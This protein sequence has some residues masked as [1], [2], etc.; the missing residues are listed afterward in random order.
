MRGT[1]A[2]EIAGMTAATMLAERA[3]PTKGR[4][5]VIPHLN[6]SGLSYGDA[7]NPRP[8]WIR[9]EAASGVRYLRYGSRFVHPIHQ[10]RIT[11]YNVCY[12]K[13]LRPGY[14]RLMLRCSSPGRLSRPPGSR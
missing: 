4:L 9:L 11:S 5:I 14:A 12:T 2:N 1:H 8:S 10:G 13:L 7:D 6:S 3:R